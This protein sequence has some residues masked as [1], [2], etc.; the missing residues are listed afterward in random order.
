MLALCCWLPLLGASS[1]VAQSVAE[2]RYVSPTDV[3][4]HGALGDD[5]E[6]GAVEITVSRRKGEEGDLVSGHV[7][8]T[9][10]IKAPANA[11]FEDTMPRLWDVDGDGH[12][13]V[14]VVISHQDHGAQLAVIGYDGDAFRYIA[15]TP[16]IG[17]R[18]RWLAPV[19]AA[20]LDGDGHVE[21][22]FVLTPHLSKTLHIWR[23]RDGD[24][25]RVAQQN[26]LTNH[27]IGWDY[28]PGGLRVCDGMPELVTAN[29][30][31][32]RVMAIT[33]QDGMIRT[34]EIGTYTG[35]ADLNRALDC[36]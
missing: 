29:A 21:V 24:F 19:G 5:L 3:Y 10:R 6:W 35:P 23:Y 2:A 30:D 16:T 31:W 34:R 8:L 22:A 33:F 17:T 1:A 11:V 18:F 14:V 32:T 12:P 15:T 28:I 27:K 20:D 9:Y 36:Q 25:R 7:D 4:P 26:G 13:E